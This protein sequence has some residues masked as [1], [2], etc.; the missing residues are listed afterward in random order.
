MTT[1]ERERDLIALVE[2]H[3]ESKCGALLGAARADADAMVR[4]ALHLARSRVR[5]AIAEERKR[6]ATAVSAAQAQLQTRR[7]LS[8]QGREALLLARGWQWIPAALRER[9]GDATGRQRWIHAHFGRALE[10]LPRTPW[11]VHHAP[12]WPA[13]DHQHT[14]QW[15]VAQGAPTIQF[16]AD[17]G[18]TA[19][20]RVHAGHNALDATAEGLVGDRRAIEGRLLHYL[21]A[22]GE[23]AP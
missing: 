13:E 6:Y 9:W 2:A 18:I 10:L 15:L 7:R 12:D 14:L 11:Q 5:E 20:F 23:E 1:L 3:R 16:I 8:R 4:N 22:G 21:E 17:Q 19:G